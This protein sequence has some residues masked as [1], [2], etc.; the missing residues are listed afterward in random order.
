MAVLGRGL[1]GRKAEQPKGNN[2]IG[3]EG[4]DNLSSKGEPN[5][6]KPRAKKRWNLPGADKEGNINLGTGGVT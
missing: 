2:E 6:R 1:L 3:I 4:R 5:W